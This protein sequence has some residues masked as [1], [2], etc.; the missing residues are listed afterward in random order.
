MDTYLA[1]TQWRTPVENHFSYPDPSQF[2]SPVF[3]VGSLG[4]SEAAA[5]NRGEAVHM[6]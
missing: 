4:R 3:L 6:R 5:T 2:P 1:V